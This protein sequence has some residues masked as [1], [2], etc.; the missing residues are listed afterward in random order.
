MKMFIW[1]NVDELTGSWHSD[2]GLVMTAETLEK[3]RDMIKAQL[4]QGCGALSQE[5]DHVIEVPEGT[6]IMVVFP[7]AGCC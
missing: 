1:E 6:Q 2:G 5:P 4:P 7:N 3:A